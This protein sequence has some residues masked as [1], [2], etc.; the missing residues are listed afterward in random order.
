MTNSMVI[1]DKNIL[2]ILKDMWK[3][4]IK[5]RYWKEMQHIYYDGMYF[6][7]TD[8]RRIYMYNPGSGCPLERGFYDFANNTLYNIPLVGNF[9][10]YRRVIPDLD[11]TWSLLGSDMDIRLHGVETVSRLTGYTFNS[12]F[13]TKMNM[14]VFSNF[15]IKINAKGW[16]SPI[17]FYNE[18]KNLL[19][20]FMPM[21]SSFDLAETGAVD[22]AAFRQWPKPEKE[23]MNA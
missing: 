20:E 14:K 1:E 3:C 6:V 21:A 23:I 13:M 22:M 4:T 8:H 18:E 17:V 16:Q 15:G 12:E 11:K 7:A 10:E 9:P 19:Y 5:N 2:G